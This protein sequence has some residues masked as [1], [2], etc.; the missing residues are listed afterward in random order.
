MIADWVEVTWPFDSEFAKTL[1]C[2][3]FKKIGRIK[4]YLYPT[5]LFR[6][7]PPDSEYRKKYEGTWSYVSDAGKTSDLSYSGLFYTKDLEEAKRLIGT[8]PIY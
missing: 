7:D 5:Q 6:D 3:Y 8:K 2:C 4:Y 1:S